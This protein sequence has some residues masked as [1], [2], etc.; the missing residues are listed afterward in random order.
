MKGDKFYNVKRLK[1]KLQ[2]SS[3]AIFDFYLYEYEDIPR[4]RIVY[5]IVNMQYIVYA[6]KE[7]LVY[8]NLKH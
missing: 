6:N 8:M 2:K 1:K 7:Q 5:Y 3:D 4:G